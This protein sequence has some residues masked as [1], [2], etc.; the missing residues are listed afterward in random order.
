MAGLL[1]IMQLAIAIDFA[2]IQT[3]QCTS[4]A[5]SYVLASLNIS[6]AE[7]I[8]ICISIIYKVTVYVRCIHIRLHVR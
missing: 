4:A 2:N 7:R 8:R 6:L 1:G 5:A 3:Y